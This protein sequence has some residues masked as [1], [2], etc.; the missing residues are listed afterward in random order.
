MSAVPGKGEAGDRM[1]IYQLSLSDGRTAPLDQWPLRILINLQ[2]ILKSP[3][4]CE[5][6]C[7]E[8]GGL[9]AAREQL[10]IVISLKKQELL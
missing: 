3:L 5:V 4:A 9:D 2:N 7:S 10:E 8:E 6:H 1:K